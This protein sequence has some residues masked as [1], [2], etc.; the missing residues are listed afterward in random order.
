MSPSLSA[1]VSAST[2]LGSTDEGHA[3]QEPRQ[4]AF[5]RKPWSSP[6]TRTISASSQNHSRLSW[7]ASLLHL[8]FYAPTTPPAT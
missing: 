7:S 5:V 1:E 8:L 6:A 2:Q 3:D 4:A